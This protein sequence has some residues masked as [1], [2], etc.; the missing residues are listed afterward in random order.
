MSEWITGA[1]G[2]LGQHVMRHFPGAITRRPDLREKA[3][4]FDTIRRVRPDRV[5]HLAYPGSR[6]IATSV[7]EPL[8]LAADLLRIDTNVIEICAQEGVKKLLCLGS[9]CGYPEVTTTPT[10]ESQLW[11]GYPEPVNAAYGCAKRMQWVLLQAARQQYGLNGIHLILANL[12][13][14]GDRSGHVIPSLIRKIRKAQKDGGPVVVWGHP[15]VTRS[16]LYV[17][18]AAEGIWR[19]MERYDSPEPLNLCST[20]EVSMRELVEHLA[21]LLEYSGPIQFDTSKPT[22]HR[23]RQFNTDRLAKALDWVP[24]M[25]LT[26][27]LASMVTWALEEET[28]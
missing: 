14:P 28:V 13:G 20:D 26:V 2:F 27:G 17:E 6:G 8:S 7:E 25:P 12:Y 23:R 4:V 1:S 10:D 18:D 24:T 3:A 9:V 11:T 21:L 19:A 22:G 5:I 15:D 16:F